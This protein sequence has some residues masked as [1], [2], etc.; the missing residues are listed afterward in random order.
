MFPTIKGTMRQPASINYCLDKCAK[1][2]GL[3]KAITSH[4]MRRTTNNL[5]RKT[6]GEIVA[7]KVTGHVTQQM[8]E[9]YSDVD[10]DERA[11]ALHNAFGSALKKAVLPA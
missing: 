5:L 9:H 3:T 6:A 1:R 11:S 2:A 4:A 7:R 10:R 8:T